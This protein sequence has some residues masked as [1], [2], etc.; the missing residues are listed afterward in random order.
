MSGKTCSDKEACSL[1]GDRIP[2]GECKRCRSIY[3]DCVQHNNYKSAGLLDGAVHTSGA[4]INIPQGQTDV[5]GFR[6]EK[7]YKL[8]LQQSCIRAFHQVKG[9][10]SSAEAVCVSDVQEKPCRIPVGEHLFFVSHRLI[11]IHS[12]LFVGE[13]KNRGGRNIRQCQRVRSTS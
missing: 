5:K 4:S 3:Q 10:S 13:Q 9:K 8:I 6:H 7:R 1:H 12:L 11:I 2:D